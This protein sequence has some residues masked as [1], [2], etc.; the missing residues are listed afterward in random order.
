[1]NSLPTRESFA[2]RLHTK[3]AMHV[4][5]SEPIEVELIEVRGQ[6]AS[7]THESFSLMFRAPV[8]APAHQGTFRLEH[9]SGDALD[10]FLVPVKKDATGLFYE[11]VFNYLPA[12]A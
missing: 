2:G 8:G 6:A 3:F 12:G 4:D 10:V 11:A 7:V 5:E 1:M 9:E